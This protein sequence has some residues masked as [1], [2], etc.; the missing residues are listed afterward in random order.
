MPADLGNLRPQGSSSPKTLSLSVTIISVT[1]KEILTQFPLPTIEKEILLNHV[2][3]KD[4]SY[5]HAHSEQELTSDQQTT[6]QKL[7]ER[8]QKGEPI[9][10]V[11]NTAYFYGLTFYVDKH[12]LIPRQETEDLV[13]QALQFLKSSKKKS[14][15]VVDIGTGSG[16]II[17][18][19]AK[20]VPK[21]KEVGLMATDI[22][23]E[24]L[25]IAQK[26]AVL[27]HVREKITFLQG[28][29]TEP[30]SGKFDLICANL[31]YVR[32]HLY[33]VLDPQIT[34]EPKVAIL[35]GE[36]GMKYYRPLLDQL[37]QYLSPNGLLLYEIDGRIYN[38][39]G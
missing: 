2:L 6:F 23:R 22:S 4:K 27:N 20:K 5:L 12:V 24:A 11:T 7:L 38:R 36:D 1:I 31:P 34:W 16:N 8:R 30:L 18:S 26:N 15:R 37:D 13:E 14:L 9:Q 39:N 33:G 32:D 28:N 21:D 29:L 19:L 3:K 17:I 35:G 25:N 10:Y